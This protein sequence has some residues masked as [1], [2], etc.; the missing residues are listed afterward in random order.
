MTKATVYAVM[1]ATIEIPV[2]A[3]S[4]EENLQQMHDASMREAEGILRNKL[5]ADVRLIGKVEFSHATVRAD[6]P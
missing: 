5:P 6:R 2:R 1:R 3:S 4:S